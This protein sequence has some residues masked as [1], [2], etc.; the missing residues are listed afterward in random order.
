MSTKGDVVMLG[1]P[2]IPLPC[3]VNTEGDNIGA[4]TRRGNA[5]FVRSGAGKDKAK[6]S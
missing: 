3:Q 4:I 2:L 1:A 5:P 6:G